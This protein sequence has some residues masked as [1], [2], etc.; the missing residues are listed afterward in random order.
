MAARTFFCLPYYE[1]EIRLEQK[2]DLI[3]YRLV[4]DDEPVVEFQASWRIGKELPASHPG[5]R[6]FFLTE[7]YVLYIENDG[8]LYQARVHHQPW[9]L[10]QAEL[11]A[12]TQT[13]LARMDCP[14]LKVNRCC[15]TQN[16]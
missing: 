1:A 4:R 15:I 16:E 5:S 14:N 9:Q 8:K 13:S 12:L 10:R 2:D 7:R 3:N 11:E 6:E